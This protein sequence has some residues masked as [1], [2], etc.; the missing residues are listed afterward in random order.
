MKI[1]KDLHFY[2]QENFYI[3][4]AILVGAFLVGR[5]GKKVLHYLLPKSLNEGQKLIVTKF[6]HYSIN[7]FIIFYALS[8][9]GVDLKVIL[10]AAGILSVALGF[11]SQTSASN[12]ISGLFILLERPFKLGDTIEIDKLT[13]IVVS[14]DLLSTK[15]RT[16]QN[17]MVRVPNETLMK[18]NIMNYTHYPIR[19][20]DLNINIDF[21]ANLQVVEKLILKLLDQSTDCLDEP[22]PGFWIEGTGEFAYRVLITFWVPTNNF[23]KAKNNIQNEIFHILK[24]NNITIPVPTRKILETKN[25]DRNLDIHEL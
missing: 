10:G 12:L 16:F 11:A 19:R 6:V 25:R 22:A 21:E 4:I 3:G 14:I 24:N 2:Q 15:L 18:T 23:G 5:D 13:G 17:L 1:S 20:V 9:M 8:L 7:L